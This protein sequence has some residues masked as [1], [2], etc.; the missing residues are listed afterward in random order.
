MMKSAWLEN[1]RDILI[2]PFT[3]MVIIPLLIYSPGAQFP[4]QHLLIIL[5]GALCI[6]AGLSLFA[7][8][9]FLFNSIAK[10]TLAPW[11]SKQKLVVTGPYA[12]CRNPMI[13]GVWLIV[14]GEALVLSSTAIL[15]W[16]LVFLIINTFYF[17]LYEE[18]DL[19][20]KFGDTC[21]KYK[22]HVPRW[23]P[24]IKPYKCDG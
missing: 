4:F 15:L 6:L 13:T 1:I 19:A 22:K 3:V 7:C 11:S 18:P 20:D 10:G 9:L 12:Y 8:T 17:L 16:S 5:S 2:I 23:I 14:F 24:R 21:L